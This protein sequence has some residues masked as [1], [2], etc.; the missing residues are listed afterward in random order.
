[1]LSF[2]FVAFF[3][4]ATCFDRSTYFS[5]RLRYD[6]VIDCRPPLA[7]LIEWANNNGYSPRDLLSTYLIEVHGEQHYQTPRRFDER[8]HQIKLNDNMKES[9][10]RE[11]G[12]PL[13]VIPHWEVWDSEALFQRVLGFVGSG[14]F[15]DLHKT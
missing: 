5:G 12:C 7:E 10:A 13:L 2:T 4:L 3:R 14:S 6:V 9:L 1:M 8:L 15:R 11:Y